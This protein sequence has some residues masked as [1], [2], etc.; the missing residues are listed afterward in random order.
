MWVRFSF[1]ES[2]CLLMFRLSKI[3]STI[4]ICQKMEFLAAHTHHSTKTSAQTQT[5]TTHSDR[6]RPSVWERL[7]CLFE[8]VLLP[9]YCSLS[10]FHSSAEPSSAPLVCLLPLPLL[11]NLSLI[12]LFLYFCC[13]PLPAANYLE[14]PLTWEWVGTANKEEVRLHTEKETRRHLFHH[15]RYDGSGSS[16]FAAS[17]RDG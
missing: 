5:W 11:T 9:I 17:C 4:C 2:C 13:W 14:P 7:C 10:A 12:Y 3:N 1:Q 16:H 6:A 8:V 15:E